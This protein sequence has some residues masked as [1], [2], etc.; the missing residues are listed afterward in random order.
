[1]TFLPRENNGVRMGLRGFDES[2]FPIIAPRLLSEVLRGFGRNW[3]I[4][5]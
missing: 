3:D 1:L 2:L 5:G 4:F